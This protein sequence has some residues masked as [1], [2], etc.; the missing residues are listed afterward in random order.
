MDILDLVGRPSEV[1]EDP[2]V[3][4]VII[5]ATKES[6]AFDIIII[7]VVSTVIAAG[8]LFLIKKLYKRFK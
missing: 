7:S 6:S 2:W 3:Q 5:D 8:V 4:R 1:I